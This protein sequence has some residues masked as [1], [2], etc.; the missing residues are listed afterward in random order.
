MSSDPSV[1]VIDI[2][3]NS[4]K[5]LVAGCGIDGLPKTL[6]ERT[7]ETRI[8][9]GIDSRSPVLSE[10]AMEAGVAAVE[11][12]CLAMKAYHPSVVKIVATSAVRDAGNGCVFAEGVETVTGIPLTILSG[13]QEALGIA[14]GLACDPAVRNQPDFCIFDLGGGSLEYIE[15]GVGQVQ[16]AVSMQLGAVRLTERFIPAINEP[17]HQSA[18]EYI[19]DHCF[20]VLKAAGVR[21]SHPGLVVGTGGGFSVSRLILGARDGRS[22]EASL[23][24]L[25]VS[26]LRDLLFQISQVSLNDRLT[27]PGLPASRADIYPAALATIVAVADYVGTTEFIHSFYNLRF[28]IAA[29]LL[30]EL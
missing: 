23:P 10:D 25:L 22:A 7:A 28:G 4:I 19:W 5:C 13:E 9:A 27:I 11:Q 18:L 2:G 12:L 6:F 24:S 17:V 29:D 30:G 20:D 14:R 8:S 26:D 1:G 15:F 16:C 3:S 21:R